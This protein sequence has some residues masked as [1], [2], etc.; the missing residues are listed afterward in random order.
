[1]CIIVYKP[2]NTKFPSEN[3]LRECFQ[4]NDD[5]AGFMF[6]SNNVVH[7]KKGFMTFEK[8]Y[9]EKKHKKVRRKFAIRYAL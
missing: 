8:F 9:K 2:Q 4:N 5:G 1:M 6:S 3:T 7:I